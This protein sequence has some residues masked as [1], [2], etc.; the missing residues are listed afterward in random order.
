MNIQGR[1]AGYPLS[2]PRV[3]L[4][5]AAAVAIALSG[6]GPI[7]TTNYIQQTK[8]E[9]EAARTADAPVLAPYE[10]TAAMAYLEKTR[11]E[12][13]YAEFA[14]SSEL[15][16]K[17]LKYARSARVKAM[18][19]KAAGALPQDRPSEQDGTEGQKAESAFSEDDEP[20]LPE[21]QA[22]AAAGIR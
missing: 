18:E 5:A 19:A 2:A 11:E 21:E 20:K 6:C 9:L 10:Y 8:S 3:F 4:L 1:Q 15:G 7:Q 17:A 14:V 22:S 12:N 16:E 13:G